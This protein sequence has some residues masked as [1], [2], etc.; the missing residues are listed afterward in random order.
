VLIR[1][2]LAQ[3]EQQL[4]TPEAYNQIFSMHGITMIFWYALPILSG[5]GNP[6]SLSRIC[7]TC[8]WAPTFSRS[9]RRFTTG[10][11]R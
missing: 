6:T 4:L 5:F 8:W 10:C 9:S 7:T 3:P 11:R 1:L 2:Q